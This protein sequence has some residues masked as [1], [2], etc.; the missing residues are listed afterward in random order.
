MDACQQNCKHK[1]GFP[2]KMIS[3]GPM[4]FIRVKHIVRCENCGME[5]YIDEK[6]ARKLTAA[7]HKRKAAE[8]E[9]E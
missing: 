5:K 1:W 2:H 8:A 3:Q 4:N 7:Y 9:K 6:E